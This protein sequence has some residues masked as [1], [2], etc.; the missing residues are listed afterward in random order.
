MVRGAAVVADMPTTRVEDMADAVDLVAVDRRPDVQD[1]LRSLR[2][3]DYCV[4]SKVYDLRAL[5]L[6]W[7][8]FASQTQ[9]RLPRVRQ[10]FPTV[11]GEAGLLARVIDLCATGIERV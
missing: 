4:F 11:H 1:R 3:F 5:H 9:A 7:S 10:G 6:S 8:D 2:C